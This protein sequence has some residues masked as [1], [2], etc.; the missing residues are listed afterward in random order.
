M[1]GFSKLAQCVMNI[2]D[3]SCLVPTACAILPNLFPD[4]LF[5]SN[6]AHSLIRANK[7][8]YSEVVSFYNLI[9]AEFFRRNTA[10]SL[11]LIISFQPF[12]LF[13]CL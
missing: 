3:F 9:K 4:I 7:I 6:F 5:G 2:S 12:A 11:K 1:I 10:F 8:I 13:V